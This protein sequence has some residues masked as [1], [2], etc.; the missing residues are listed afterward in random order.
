MYVADQ[1]LRRAARRLFIGTLLEGPGRRLAD[2]IPRAL[3]ENDR[4][5]FG[6]MR[7]LLEPTSNCIDIGCH[8]GL[9]L[10][11]MLALAPAGRH[12]AFEPIPYLYETLQQRFGG[13]SRVTL[14][15]CALSDRDDKTVFYLNRDNPAF[16]GLR[17]RRYPDA[18]DRVNEISVEVR[19]LDD[20]I[21]ADM[22]ISLMKIDVEG[23]EL[24][25]L[26]G[27]TALIARTRPVI[28]FEFGTG[29]AE[30]YGST[31]EGLYAFFAEQHY[32]L[33]SLP[34]T[35]AGGSPLKECDLVRHFETNDEY[36]FAGVPEDFSARVQSSR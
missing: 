35:D 9:Y 31:P 29:S 2:L 15:D 28:V 13:D 4:L 34:V 10:A 25:V 23:A 26:R 27:A 1:W 6:W 21:P 20:L 32:Q 36:Y 16:S 5:T 18:R 30:F 33:Y 17:R 8:K 11:E 7:R 19:R 12:F 14:F 22:P 24:P 3:D